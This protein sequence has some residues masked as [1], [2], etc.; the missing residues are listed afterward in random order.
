MTQSAKGSAKAPKDA[1]FTKYEAVINGFLDT[2][3]KG[4]IEAAYKE[5]STTFQKLTTLDD[6][7]TLIAGY[8]SV[9]NIPTSACTLTQYSDP[10]TTTIKGLPDVYTVVQAKCETTENGK[11]KGFYVEFMNDK[12]TPRI[13]YLSAYNNPVI[14]NKN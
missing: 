8:Q 10:Y 11:I 3:R 9:Q 12:G 5:T 14:H 1:N 2:I 4:Q 6:F 13:S 7:K